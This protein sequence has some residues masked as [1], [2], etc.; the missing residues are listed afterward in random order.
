M[1][2]S[3]K[4]D[5]SLV[6]DAWSSL[7]PEIHNRIVERTVTRATSS[8]PGRGSDRIPYRADALTTVD[9]G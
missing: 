2:K 1:R 5:L 8:I 4:V 3:S 7:F 6:T 9:R